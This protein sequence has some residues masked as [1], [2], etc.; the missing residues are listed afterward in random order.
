MIERGWYGVNMPREYGGLGRSAFDRLILVEEF[1]RMGAPHLD[2][3]ITS[4]API[5]ARYGTPDNRTRWLAPI[6][7]GDVVMA[8]GYSEP[9]AGTDLASLRTTAELDGDRWV[10]NGQKT[11]NSRAHLATH[12]W[13]AVRTDPFAP[14]HGGISILIVPIDLPGVEIR[15][16][17]TWG[18]D[19]TNLT[20]FDHVRVPA[21]NLFGELNRGWSYI[22][23]ALAHE[24]VAMGSAGALLRLF[25]HL[26]RHCMQVG[27]DG[28]RP[29][30][31]PEVRSRLALLD[32]DLTT[33]RLFGYRTASLIDSGVAL[34]SEAATQ[35]VFVSELRTR[36]AEVALE[37]LG[38][39]GRLTWEDPEAPIGGLAEEMYRVAP[40]HRFGGG[41]SEVMRDVIARR[42]LGMPRSR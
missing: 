1:E 29:A 4:I 5:I 3:T 12:E 30:D 2:M 33:A 22:Q 9:D 7:R 20:F 31:R 27:P 11:W 25:D 17:Y 8:L 32:V 18:Y 6:M 21:E 16:L 26:V 41:T 37:I 34:T 15:P 13:L 14:Q 40:M 28:H 24:R 36:L 23:G 10:V 35:K 38:P 39:V 19:R 42:G